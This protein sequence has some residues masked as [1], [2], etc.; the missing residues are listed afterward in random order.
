MKDCNLWKLTL[1]ILTYN[2]HK[3]VLRNIRYWSNKS[4]CVRVVDGS[5]KAINR[6]VLDTFPNNIIYKY[7]T[8]SYNQRLAGVIPDLDTEYV[9]LMGDDE[10]FVPSVLSSCIEELEKDS[11]LVSC[12]GVS[13]GFFSRNGKVFGKAAYPKLID[14]KD[15]MND[16]PINRLKTHMGNYAPSSIYGVNRVR[17]WSISMDT[18]S[19]G[20][21]DFFANLELSF[22]MCMCFSGKTKVIN[23]LMWLRSF[24]LIPVRDINP[25][26]DSNTKIKEWWY[27][28]EYL[29]NRREYIDVM[30]KGFKKL[31][32]MTNLNFR[33]AV[34]EGLES[35]MGQIKEV[36]KKSIIEKVMDALSILPLPIKSALR[37]ILGGRHVKFYARPL[38]EQAAL[39]ESKGV[40]VDY[41][42]LDVFD[43][44]IC[45][46]NK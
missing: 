38:R 19:K 36:K 17:P 5:D 42:E 30:S 20:E 21:F 18:I 37:L 44:L 32:N 25:E 28:P 46:F 7:D 1:V 31:N 15:G 12:S 27:G 16:D 39:L 4:I 35:F 23:E 9:A 8:S 14:Y 13:M 43:K 10:F 26:L 3:Y 24:D 40:N 11:S 41:K 29:L 2:R 22:E 34:T 33:M 45:D 6:R